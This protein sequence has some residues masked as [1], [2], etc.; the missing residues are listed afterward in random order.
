MNTSALHQRG[1]DMILQANNAF[2]MPGITAFV[3]NCSTISADRC[4][5]IA[6]AEPHIACCFDKLTRR[7]M[8]ICI[9]VRFMVCIVISLISGQELMSN[10][11][12]HICRIVFITLGTFEKQRSRTA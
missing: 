6:R 12:F 5:Q 8:L 2:N 7:L 10:N 4:L 9:V 3:T 11:C 1:S